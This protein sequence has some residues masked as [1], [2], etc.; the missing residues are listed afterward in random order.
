MKGSA[1]GLSSTRPA[2]WYPDPAGSPRSRW[3]D[4]TAWTGLYQQAQDDK[5]AASC[6][7]CDCGSVC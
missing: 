1:F 3:F 4:G 7:C 5:A 6:S 2:G